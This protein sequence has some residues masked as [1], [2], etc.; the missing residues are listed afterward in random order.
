MDDEA[1]PVRRRVLA[2][3]AE[4]G[5]F[6]TGVLR[7]DATA[8]GAGFRRVSLMKAPRTRSTGWQRLDDLDGIC[9]RGFNDRNAELRASAARLLGDVASFGGFVDAPF[10]RDLARSVA[11]VAR[12]RHAAGGPRTPRTAART[13]VV[14]AAAARAL[15][16]LQE[17]DLAVDALHD[18]L[19][20]DR[21]PLRAARGAS[22]PDDDGDGDDAAR[23]SSPR[24]AAAAAGPAAGHAVRVAPRPAPVVV[25]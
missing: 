17:D 12:G 15:G 24:A 18:A 11:A 8:L 16:A 20:L 2:A 23:R 25:A 14:R 5:A 7:D 3:L 1:P 19:R 21:E 4:D 13:S 9:R 10:K 6:E 22:A